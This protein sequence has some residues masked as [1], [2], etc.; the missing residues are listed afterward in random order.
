MAVEWTSGVGN[1]FNNAQIVYTSTDLWTCDIKKEKE[2]IK[3][4]FKLHNFCYLLLTC[5]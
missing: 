3:I 1:S 2:L 4:D 5:L